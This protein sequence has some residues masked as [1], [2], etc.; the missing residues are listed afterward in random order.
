M[1]ALRPRAFFA[2]GGQRNHAWPHGVR[3]CLGSLRTTSV[4]GLKNATRAVG[5][6]GHSRRKTPADAGGRCAIFQDQNPSRDGAT[7]TSSATTATTARTDFWTTDEFHE[8]I[9]QLTLVV[10]RP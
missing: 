9:I 2:P 6:P 7:Q 5:V 1:K 10:N 8:L 4:E 3:P